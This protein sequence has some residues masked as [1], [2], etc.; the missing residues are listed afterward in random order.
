MSTPLTLFCA[1]A[2]IEAEKSR[3]DAVNFIS[4]HPSHHGLTINDI[5]AP[6]SKSGDWALLMRVAGVLNVRTHTMAIVSVPDLCCVQ[7]PA[8]GEALL[9]KLVEV[10]A[11]LARA[12]AGDLVVRPLPRVRRIGR[13]VTQ[14]SRR[15][16]V[17]PRSPPTWR[18]SR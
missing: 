5:L 11:G 6:L 18:A 4:R 16:S 12:W 1:C 13:Q 2:A 9:R 17:R 10:N 8:F 14:V 7:L 15:F 3:A